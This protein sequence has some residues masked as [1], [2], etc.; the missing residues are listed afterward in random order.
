M[1]ILVTGSGGFIGSAIS[2]ALLER[3]D[4]VVGLDDINDYYDT[5]LKLARL[6]RL[7]SFKNFS[8][9][10]SDVTNFSELQNVFHR[11]GQFS[12]VVHL[13]ANAGVRY[14]QDF[15]LEA[16]NSNI[17]GHANLL[18]LCRC[19]DDFEHFVFASS[20][21]VYADDEQVPYNIDSRIDRP[22][23]VYAATK[24]ADELISYVYSHNFDM[25]QTAL[26][27]FTVYG[28]WG[29]PDMA[30]YL[31]TDLIAR[32]KP[33]QVFNFGDMRRDFVHINDAVQGIILSLD[34][35][36]SSDSGDVAL[37][38]FNIGSGQSESLHHLISQIEKHLNMRA[39]KNLESGPRGEIT[40][41]LADISLTRS[42]LGFSPSVSFGEGIEN[43]VEWYRNFH[44]F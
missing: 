36:P 16:V 18:E 15:P 23:S 40:E 42:Q 41:T 34:N 33:I 10:E 17:V 11:H 3:G 30:Y 29:R 2:F 19:M 7:K 5:N 43:F 22:R 8:F 20:A 27:F 28:P 14:S 9:V 1:T 35:P 32:S 26:R 6:S 37:Q 38:K 21:S 13:A 39:I 25:K 24:A 44:G 12:H 31:F 4:E